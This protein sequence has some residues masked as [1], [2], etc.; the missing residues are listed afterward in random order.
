MRFLSKPAS[1]KHS[2]K[3]LMTHQEPP[4]RS[5]ANHNSQA[6]DKTIS[7]S[8][9][10]TAMKR[11]SWACRNAVGEV[12]IFNGMIGTMIVSYIQKVMHQMRA[13]PSRKALQRLRQRFAEDR[14]GQTAGAL[15]FTT[16]IALVPL[17]TVSLAVVTAFPLF[18]QFQNVL[19][20]WLIESLIPD[21]ISR[22]VLGYLTQFTTKASRLG[23]VS[24]AALMF[25]ALALV[26]TIDRSL[27]AIWRVN[28][29]R[30]WGQRLLLYWAALTL[31]PV[32]VAA[33]LVT[34][35]SVILWSGG[36]LRSQSPTMKLA[37][38]VLEFVLLWGGISA[39]YRFVPNTH[40]PWRQV[41]GGSL[42]TTV[43]LEIARSLLTWY[44]ARM[45]TFS[46][47]YGAFAT[48]PILLVWIY[49]TWVIVL[50]GAVLVASWPGLRM[51]HVRDGQA[52]G[53]GFQLALDTLREL[54]RK[55]AEGVHGDDLQSLAN[56]LGADPLQMQAVLE[57]LQ[58]L[59]WVGL[60]DE[61]QPSSPPRYVLLV[62]W[63]STRV[64]P[65]LKL[66]L[67]ADEPGSATMHKQWHNWLLADVL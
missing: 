61:N 17:I 36:S 46:L 2:G 47:V 7:P 40:V 8:K 51:G 67:L 22:Q 10:P 9:L 5:G 62:D 18:D 25:S 6:N 14:L 63:R 28:K 64:A 19:Q 43:V 34:M 33:G 31:G 39:L 42:G 66:T 12:V 53:A 11:V 55:Q 29:A 56:R 45:S 1:G 16:T 65:L 44:L 30:P 4:G 15:T 32:L 54:K 37:L 57:Q 52:P 20:R 59:D 38:D 41:L 27:N 35:A 60:L 26:F 50:L 3:A 48:V 24:F 13:F 49:M 21:S 58:Q 23:V